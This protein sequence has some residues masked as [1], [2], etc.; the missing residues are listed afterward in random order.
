MGFI[1]KLKW[2]LSFLLIFFLVLATNLIDKNNFRKIKNSIVTI[3][4]DRLVANDLIFE[5]LQLT[6]EKEMAVAVSDDDFFKERNPQ[7]NVQLES[8]T[9]TYRTTKLTSKEAIVF[10][11]LQEDLSQLMV[12]EE[13]MPITNSNEAYHLLLADIKQSLHK[14]SKIQLEEGRNQ[15]VMSK[16]TVE[17]VESFTRIENYFLI[18]LAILIPVIIFGST[19]SLK[20]IFG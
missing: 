13:L 16:N 8:L 11:A 10:G 17:E 15:M 18:F 6:H 7:V 20:Q 9:T 12:M 2:V 3:Y 1:N 14:L 4:E 5:Y 19:R